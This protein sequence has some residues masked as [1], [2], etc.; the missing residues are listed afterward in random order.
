MKKT[1]ILA[2][3]SI[4]CFNSSFGQK[5]NVSKE[6]VDAQS[7]GEQTDDYIEKTIYLIKKCQ[8][9][10]ILDDL[11]SYAKKIKKE[12]DQAK[13]ELRSAE[14]AAESAKSEAEDIECDETKDELDEA[15][16]NFSNSLSSLDAA[17][18][19]LKRAEN[20]EDTDDFFYYLKKAKGEIEDGLDDLQTALSDLIEA[21]DE[22]ENCN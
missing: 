18:L 8:Q 6:I 5:N 10:I 11:L 1:Y 20:V 17:Y 9:V 15:I 12:L 19:Y 22:L 16:D 13:N 7:Y 21:I 3:F 4:I 14:S 2:L